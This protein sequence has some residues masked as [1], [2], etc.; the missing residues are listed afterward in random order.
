MDLFVIAINYRDHFRTRII[1][2]DREIGFC[3]SK[4]C[5]LETTRNSPSNICL[6]DVMTTR[7]DTLA[8]SFEIYFNVARANVRKVNLVATSSSLFDHHEV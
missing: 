6:W 3:G 5:V 8:N 1:E 4:R 2:Y 7:S